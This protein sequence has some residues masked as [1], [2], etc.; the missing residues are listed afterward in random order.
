MKATAFID[1]PLMLLKV[2][3]ISRREGEGRANGTESPSCLPRSTLLL[4]FYSGVGQLWAITPHHTENP[5]PLSVHAFYRLAAVRGCP[6]TTRSQ[7]TS[8]RKE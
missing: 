8:S 2:R 3:S 4:V 1:S 7:S 6:A 5:S